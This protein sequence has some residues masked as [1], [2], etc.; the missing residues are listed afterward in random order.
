MLDPPKTQ[1][2]PAW[3]L[4]NMSLSRIQYARCLDA[5]FRSKDCRARR[6]QCCR[7]LQNIVWWCAK[8]AANKRNKHDGRF[9]TYNSV[10]AW[11]ELFPYLSAAQIRLA[12]DKLE[13][14]G[15]ILSGTFNEVGYDRTK[16]YCSIRS[17]PFVRNSKWNC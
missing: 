17:I 14:D 2:P 11:A 9:W 10:K 5:Q 13:S 16:W 4:I 7:A 15:L 1:K 8:N 3:H 12:L 6:R